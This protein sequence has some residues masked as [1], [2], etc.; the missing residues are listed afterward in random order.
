LSQG[1]VAKKV[2]HI[3]QFV[4]EVKSAH[5]VMMNGEVNA[6]KIVAQL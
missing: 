3:E 4:A 2:L 5:L 6:F 1:N